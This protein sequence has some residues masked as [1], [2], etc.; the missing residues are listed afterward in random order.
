MDK[1]SAVWLSHSSIGDFLKCPRLY[2]LRVLYRDPKTGHKITVMTPPLALGQAV[3]D[4]INQLSTLSSKE[5]FLVSP[6]E[7]FEKAWTKVAGERGGF[8]SD[9]EEGQY[10]ERGKKMLGIV[11]KNPGPLARPAIKINT[12]D[13]LPYYW[14]DEKENI[15][16]CGKIDWLEYLKGD[17]SIHIIDFKTGRNE[18]DDDSLQL[19]IYLLLASNTQ[20][21][22]VSKA[23][24][25]YLDKNVEPTEIK[26]PEEDDSIN[27]IAGIA[28]RIALARK[29]GHFKCPTN[30]CKYCYPLE[31]VL[32]NHGKLVG[33]SEYSQD[34]YILN[35]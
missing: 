5:R 32:K 14:F 3:H 22:K 9:K 15:I 7:H 34:I 13:G 29:L 24:Y 2:F 12:E 19:P 6:M 28:T 1:Y 11:E 26:L 27:K 17:N 23:S 18:E 10:K 33:V 8:R 20:K 21:R 31:E 30:G 35:K 16:L 25:W 4:A